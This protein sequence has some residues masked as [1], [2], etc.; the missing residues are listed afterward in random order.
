MA[1]GGATS[2]PSPEQPR[3]CSHGGGVAGKR[4]RPARF[5]ETRGARSAACGTGATAPKDAKTS[6]IFVV[7]GKG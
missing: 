6:I 2:Y 3:G 5:R 1:A 4:W 7:F